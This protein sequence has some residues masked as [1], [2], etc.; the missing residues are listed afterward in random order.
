VSDQASVI[1]EIWVSV[2]EG[3]E[4]TGFHPDHVRRLARENSR[5]PEDQRFIRFRKDSHGYAIWLP[6]LMS[7]VKRTNLLSKSDIDHQ[8][9]EEAW[10]TTTEAAQLTSYNRNYLIRL[11]QKISRQPEAERQIKI[12]RRNGYELWLP[13]LVAYIEH[14]GHGPHAKPQKSS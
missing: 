2:A 12:R 7:Y 1:E 4:K 11:S 10:V 3:A 6:D 5:L 13:D 9:A 14:F 8:M